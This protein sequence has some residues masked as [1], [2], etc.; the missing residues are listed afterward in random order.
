MTLYLVD[1]SGLIHRA[2]HAIKGLRTRA[3]VPTNAV[4]GLAAMLRKFAKD[5]DPARCAV[6]FDAG[7]ETFRNEMFADYK[8]TR[9][10]TDPDLAVQFA[11]AR[12]IA[13]ALGFP[14]VEVDGFEA[15]DVIATLAVAARRAGM[16]VVIE[17]ADK[18]LF[19]LVGDGITA[20][21]P[22]RDRVFDAAGVVDKM[23]VPPERIVDYLSL[24]GDASDN[25]PG[26]AGIGAKG[27]AELINAFGGLDDIYARLDEVPQRKREALAAGRDAAML[28]RRLV[29]LAT[30]VSLPLGLDDLARRP[31]DRDALVALLTELEFKGLLNEVLAECRA[32]QADLF[33]AVPVADGAIGGAAAVP[34]GP[35]PVEVG[36]GGGLA[37]VLGAIADAPA[38]ALAASFGARDPVRPA[39][40]GLGIAAGDATFVLRPDTLADADLAALADA[41]ARRPFVAAHSKEIGQVFAARGA[42]M[43]LPAFDPVLASYLLHAERD[44]HAL[45]TLSLE[46]MGRPLP[47]VGDGSVDAVA[48]RARAARDA[49]DLLAPRID[50][51]GLRALLDDVEI[52]LARLL[53]EM[54]RTGVPVDRDTLARLSV[55]LGHDVQRLEKAILDAAGVPFN[56]NSPK[57]LADVLFGKLQLPVI[58]KTKTGPSTDVTVLE[59]LADRHPVPA[60]ILEFRSLAKLKGTYADALAGLVHPV[61][62]RI[63]TSYNQAVAATGRLSSSDPN[64]QNIPIR[65]DAGR[66]IRAAFVAAPGTEFVSADYSQIELRVLAHLS[67]DASLIEAF[68]EGRDIHARTAARVF[69]CAEADVTPD[70]RR[71]AKVVNFGLLYGM[72]PFRLARDLKI[73]QAEAKKIIDDYFGAFPR[74]RAFLDGTL[75]AARTTGFV[76]TLT[77]RRRSAEGINASKHLER[78]AA[79]RMALNMPIQGLAADIIKIAMVRLRARLLDAGLDARIVLQ[80]HDELVLE[81]AE[82]QGDAVAALLRDT[83]QGAY[84]LAVPL[85]VEVGRGRVWSELHG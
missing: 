23:G 15:D 54:E 32:G 72:G 45:E 58:K 34:P 2:F 6:V 42:R 11:P 18:D 26:V 48:A 3:G 39:C 24:V 28:S 5:H 82:G 20:H 25:V 27:A 67:G 17:S 33:A 29:T 55:E 37:G 30:D 4:Y 53:G 41:L 83:M 61:T 35:A 56:P 81:A 36:D 70:M 69:R 66:K 84:P 22:M 51:Q 52:P 44:G 9:P 49:A 50:G 10:P 31:P 71:T 40:L 43:P 14:C 57:Q 12:R 21:D 47:G 1:A 16:D 46:E 8:A 19:Q 60:L 85:A 75:E 78:A 80:V 59:E 64:L 62:G 7:R 73:S 68:R 63:H 13:E 79:E 65:T 77:G 74:V 76:S 38:V